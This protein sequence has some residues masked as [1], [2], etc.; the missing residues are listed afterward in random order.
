[1]FL[2][3]AFLLS[4]GVLYSEAHALYAALGVLT[5]LASATRPDRRSGPIA[6]GVAAALVMLARLDSVMF[7]GCFGLW[8][9]ARWRSLPKPALF[10]NLAAFGMTFLAG[11]C[12]GWQADP[13]HL[14]PGQ[15]VA[16]SQPGPEVRHVP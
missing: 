5:W 6:L 1:L 13:L 3:L 10:R 14:L 8:L 2:P 15:R 9:L 4:S 11:G 12:Q 16:G 7:V